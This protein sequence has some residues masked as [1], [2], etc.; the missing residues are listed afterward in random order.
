MVEAIMAALKDQGASDG[1]HAG[2]LMMG[3]L[4]VR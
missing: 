2:V 3:I 1:D 4:P